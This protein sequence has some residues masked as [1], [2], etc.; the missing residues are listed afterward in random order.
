[1]KRHSCPVLNCTPFRAQRGIESLHLQGLILAR[2]SR[3]CGRSS[4]FRDRA[5]DPKRESAKNLKIRHSRESGNPSSPFL[6]F[7]PH[8]ECGTGLAAE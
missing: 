1:M 2:P 4:V 6:E 8:I 3:C 7:R 5:G